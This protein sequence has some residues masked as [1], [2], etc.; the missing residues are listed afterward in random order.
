MLF[1]KNTAQASY[2]FCPS[3]GHWVVSHCWCGKIEWNESRTS[4]LKHHWELM[5][6]KTHTHKLNDSHHPNI[7]H[8]KHKLLCKIYI[9]FPPITWLEISPLSPPPWP[10]QGGTIQIQHEPCRLAIESNRCPVESGE[11]KGSYDDW[12]MFSNDVMFDWWM[13]FIFAYVY[14]I[15]LNH[16]LYICKYIYIHDIKGLWYIDIIIQ[17]H[18]DTVT[19]IDLSIDIYKYQ[20]SESC[21]VF[22]DFNAKCIGFFST[23]SFRWVRWMEKRGSRATMKRCSIQPYMCGSRKK[24]SLTVKVTRK[25]G[26][27]V[28]WRFGRCF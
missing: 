25:G 28:L 7:Y 21:C 5:K 11:G 22:P 13:Y 20:L 1:G 3:A 10:S 23:A 17:Y 2:L 15:W 12:E 24:S 9:C 19:Y 6:E 26:L 4:Y 8:Y 27:F 16:M 18:I 14:M